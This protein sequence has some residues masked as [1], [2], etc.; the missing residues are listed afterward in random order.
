MSTSTPVVHRSKK[1]RKTKSGHRN[2]SFPFGNLTKNNQTLFCKILS[3]K[4]ISRFKMI[5]LVRSQRPKI[6]TFTL[7]IQIIKK[8]QKPAVLYCGSILTTW[9]GDCLKILELLYVNGNIFDRQSTH[10]NRETCSI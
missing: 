9:N 3:S 8:T 1:F 4:K 7:S 6:D 2:N 5:T 10:W